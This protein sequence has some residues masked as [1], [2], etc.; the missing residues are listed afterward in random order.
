MNRTVR[1]K[2][3]CSISFVLIQDTQF[4]I[5]FIILDSEG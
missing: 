3:D 5:H 2:S 1:K 4:A